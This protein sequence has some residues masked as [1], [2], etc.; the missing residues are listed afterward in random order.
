M[1]KKYSDL[2][3]NITIFAQALVLYA[4][5]FTDAQ[6]ANDNTASDRFF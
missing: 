5:G 2:E 6:N 4:S 1:K 3:I